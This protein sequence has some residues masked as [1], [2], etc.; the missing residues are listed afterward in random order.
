M[1]HADMPRRL[2]S[3]DAGLF[4][5]ASGTSEIGCS[6]TKIGEYWACGLPVV[7][8]PDVSDT[9]ELIRRFGCGVVV[10]DHTDE[11]YLE[12]G[13][14]LVE[15]LAEPGVRL[16][17]RAAAEGHYALEPACDRQMQ[18]YQRLCGTLP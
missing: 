2:A 7:T 3:H 1:P 8:T 12:A 17:C 4:F 16:R 10:R 15:L 5:L 6:P 9:D 13:T 14:R 18:L 11:A